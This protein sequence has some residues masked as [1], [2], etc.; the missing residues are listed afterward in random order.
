MHKSPWTADTS[1]AHMQ[2]GDISGSIKYS[3]I[4]IAGKFY[5]RESG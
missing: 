2:M 3:C 1:Q 4:Y 5:K